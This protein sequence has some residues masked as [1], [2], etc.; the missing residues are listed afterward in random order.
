[1]FNATFVRIAFFDWLTDFFYFFQCPN[2][3]VVMTAYNFHRLILRKV[4]I[5]C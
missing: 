2:A 3:F 4:L 5:H 1:M